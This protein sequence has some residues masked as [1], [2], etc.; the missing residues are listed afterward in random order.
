[1]D[2]IGTRV[3]HLRQAASRRPF[4]IWMTLSWRITGHS[5]AVGSDQKIRSQD[6]MP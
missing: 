4:P 1:M 3:L 2:S 6:R 5:D